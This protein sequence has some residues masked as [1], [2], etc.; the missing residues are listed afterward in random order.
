M[1]KEGRVVAMGN[2][3]QHVGFA[4]FLGVL[5]AWGGGVMMGVHWMYGSVAA[6]L[7]TVG[8]LLP[9]LDSDSSVQ[10]RGFSGLLGILAAVAVWQDID[11]SPVVVPFELHLWSA[12]MTYVLVRHGLRRTLARLTVHRG[13]SHS[14]PTALIWG[15]VTYI[16]Y[17]AESHLLRVVMACA[18]ILGFLSHLVLDEWCSV[19]L[20]GRRV[21]KAFGT[22]LKFTSKSMSATIATYAILAM[23]GW[24]VVRFWPADPFSGGFPQPVIYWPGVH[25]S[26]PVDGW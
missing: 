14:I 26:G 12:I 17:P 5:Y 23:L 1:I 10:L 21:N 6:L 3:R 13:M 9:D 25:E 11:N 24:W 18:V 2:F 8:G 22:A 20:V 7:A 16:G 19:D 15:A 4:S